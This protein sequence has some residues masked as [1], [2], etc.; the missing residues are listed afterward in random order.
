MNNQTIKCSHI[1]HGE[2]EAIS[3]CQECKINMCNKCENL[4]SE[5][6][7]KHHKYPLDKDVKE[8]FTGFCQEENHFKEL[9]YF[10]KNHN[11]LCCV[12]CIGKIQDNENGQHKDCDICIIKDIK[13]EKKII[14]NEN[15]KFLQDIS[16]NIK[17]SIKELK[18][19]YEKINENKESLKINIQKLFTKIRNQINDREDKLLSEIDKK[20]EDLYIKED[21]IKKSEKLPIEI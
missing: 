18:Q 16:N 3:F 21:L 9:K 10:C 1:E 8:I 20:Y 17:K 7:K 13:N 5:L 14:L 2:N 6:F 11:K 4:H 19:I 12:A 15:I